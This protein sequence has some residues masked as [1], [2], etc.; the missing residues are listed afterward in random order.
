M[1]T[2]EKTDTPAETHYFNC[3]VHE[4]GPLLERF[5]VSEWNDGEEA[6]LT[7]KQYTL[8]PGHEEHIE[9]YTSG[10]TS[11]KYLII[12]RT[13]PYRFIFYIQDD[14]SL[15]AWRREYAQIPVSILPQK[16]LPPPVEPLKM[17]P[18]PMNLKALRGSY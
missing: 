12:V 1:P 15:S 2:H 4:F 11:A 10:W 9:L 18:I 17:I 3:N 7:K 13:P 14:A 5:S 16:F 8:L 6:L